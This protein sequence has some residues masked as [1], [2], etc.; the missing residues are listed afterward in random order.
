M[1]REHDGTLSVEVRDD[2]RGMA[3]ERRP[4]ANG[5]FAMESRA[6][7]IGAVL[8][9][10]SAPGGGTVVKIDVPLNGNGGPP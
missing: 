2:G 4:G 8:T 3:D 10:D 9:M 1:L 7:S 5:L 6:A